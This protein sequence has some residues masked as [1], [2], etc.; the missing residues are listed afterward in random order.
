MR[1][2]EQRLRSA[3]ASRPVIANDEIVLVRLH[4]A[5]ED[6][7][8]GEAGVAEALGEGIRDVGRAAPDIHA[9]E[10]NDFLVHVAHE[11]LTRRQRIGL[12]TRAGGD[13]EQEDDAGELAESLAHGDRSGRGW[14]PA[15]ICDGDV[16]AQP[17]VAPTRRILRNRGPNVKFPI[18][19]RPR[20][21]LPAPPSSG[22]RMSQRTRT[23][24][25]N[26]L[27]AIAALMVVMF[28]VEHFMATRPAWHR[29]LAFSAV[30][31]AVASRLVRGRPA[32]SAL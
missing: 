26:V 9:V 3:R 28:I 5:E 2:Q 7:L 10:F 31:I 30:S 27:L 18:H 17:P 24:I 23:I 25:A 11:L 8:L 16:A 1:E 6:V 21:P 14:G 19:D 13:G 4:A 12:R 29:D 22:E 32:R 20:R 15:R